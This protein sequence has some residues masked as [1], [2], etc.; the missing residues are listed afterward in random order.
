MKYQVIYSKRFA[1]QYKKL[2]RSGD[3]RTLQAL[4]LVIDK[5]VEGKNLLPQNHNHRLVGNLQEFFECHVLPDWLLIY[6]ID[7]D[8]MILELAATGTHSNLF[9]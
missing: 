3:R 7:G 6:R 5:L 4:D 1:R 2:G 8:I 9:K